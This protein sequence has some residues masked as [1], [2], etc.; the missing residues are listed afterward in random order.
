MPSLTLDIAGN[1]AVAS[2]GRRIAKLDDFVHDY[3]GDFSDVG[4]VVKV[5][6]LSCEAGLFNAGSNNYEQS[7]GTTEASIQVS[8]QYVAGFTVTP[9]Q[10]SDGLGAFNGLFAQFGDTAGR[11]VAKAVENAV[12]SQ[13]LSS[14]ATP[15][16]LTAT[17]AGFTGLFKTC[18]D[19]DLDPSN[20]VLVL[21]PETYAK[22]LEVVGADIVNLERVIEL[23]YV[24]NFLGFARVMC[25]YYVDSNLKG[26]LAERGAIGIVG[27]RIPA[28][29]TYPI[30]NEYIDAD[31]GVPLTMLGHQRLADGAWFVSVTGLF[32]TEIVDANHIVPLT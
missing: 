29:D 7:T 23:G 4:A 30:Y 26:F 20:T 31:T 19:K 1:K 10:M 3:A 17:K 15:V 12:V 18:Y 16:S 11:A 21:N 24:D 27:R 32:G 5:P 28:L 22:M 9:K 2:L 13:V 25:S 14:T 6:V 8:A